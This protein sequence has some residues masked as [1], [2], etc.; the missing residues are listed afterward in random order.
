VRRPAGAEKSNYGSD[1]SNNT[2]SQEYY[3]ESNNVPHNFL[4][5]AC[6]EL[7]KITNWQALLNRFPSFI[8]QCSLRRSGG[9]NLNAV[10]LSLWNNLWPNSVDKVQ[11]NREKSKW[12]ISYS[13][14][15]AVEP[16]ILSISEDY[17]TYIGGRIFRINV[18]LANIS[19]K[20]RLEQGEN[21]NLPFILK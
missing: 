8:Q 19:V 12:F 2:I 5:Q 11:T 15:I 17:Y 14:I 10:P 4:L 20:F 21:T 9:L 3:F 6:T 7:W 1:E 16:S 13:D 18:E